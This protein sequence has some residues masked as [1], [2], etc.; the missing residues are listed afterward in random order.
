M[1]EYLWNNFCEV[2]GNVGFRLEGVVINGNHH[3]ATDKIISIINADVGTPLFYIKLEQIY[4]SLKKMNW[5][6]DVY[7]QR[8]L[9]NKIAIYIKERVPVAIW[10][11]DNKLH[12]IDSEGILSQVKEFQNSL[13]FC[14]WLELMRIYMLYHCLRI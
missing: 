9:P 6:E 4:N 12:L 10:Q 5:V 13:I 3:I 11:N 8:K 1:R 14:M 2:T 7:L